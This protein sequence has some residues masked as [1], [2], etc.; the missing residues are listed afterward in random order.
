MKTNHFPSRDRYEENALQRWDN[1]GGCLGVL[2][3]SPR[4]DHLVGRRDFVAERDRSEAAPASISGQNQEHGFGSHSR[5]P[6]RGKAGNSE[7]RP[8]LAPRKEPSSEQ[9]SLS[10]IS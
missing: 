5:L 1:E 9:C 3:R 2:P 7:S 6:G 10:R 8:P 4:T